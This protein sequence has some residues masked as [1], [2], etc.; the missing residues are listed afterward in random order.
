MNL[1]YFQPHLLAIVTFLIVTMAFFGPL[2]QGKHLKQ[3]DTMRWEGMAKEII[4]FRKSEGEEPLWTNS[5]FSGMPAFQISVLYPNNLISH[6]DQA[7]AK[8]FPGPSEIIFIA[9][10][11]FYFLLISFGLTPLA[12]VAGALAFAF[13]SYN[14]IIIEAGHNTKGFAIG[15]MAIVVI[16]VVMAFRGKYLL[17]SALAALGVAF[18]VNANHLQITY[19]T[20]VLLLVFGIVETVKNIKEKT[21][22]HYFKAVSFLF[23]AAVIGVL[24]NITSLLMT[25]EYGKETIRGKSELTLNADVKTSGLD[26]DYATQWSYGIGETM[27][28]MVPNFKGGGSG[29]IGNDKSVM[30]V[31]DPQMKQYVSGM[32]RYFGDQ[33]F[34]SGPVYFGAIVCFLFILGLFIVQGHLKW[35]LLI[36]TLL[37]VMLAWGKNFMPLTDFFLDFVPGYNKF[38]AVSMTLVIAQIAMPLLGFLAI[39]KIMEQPAI[40]KEK[41]KQFLVAF[42]LTGGL[43]FLMYFMPGM[44]NDFFKE[45][46]NANLMQ[47]L[48]SNKWPADQANLLLDNLESA[49]KSIFTSDAARSGIFISLSALLVWLFSRGQL[50]SLYMLSGLLALITIDQWTV[51]KRYMNEDNFTRKN[52]RAQTFEPSEADLQILQDPDPHYRVLNVTTSTFN[53]AATSYFH[54]SVGGYHGAKLKRYQEL[55]EYHL[56]QNN[57]DVINMLNT[58]YFIVPGQD[59]RPVAQKNPAPLG[60][61]WFVNEYEMVANADSEITAL[62]SFTPSEVAIVDQRFDAYLKGLQLKNKDEGSIKLTKY[63]PNY[64]SYESTT[65]AEQLAVFSEVYYDKGWNAYI[66]DKLVDHIRANYVLRAL[67]VPEGKHKIEFKFEPASYIVGERIALAGSIFAFLFIGFALYSEQKNGAKIKND[68]LRDNAEK[69]KQATAKIKV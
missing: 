3:E 39:K 51:A 28:L 50:K 55:I 31:V 47:Q 19:Y 24:P 23:I 6:I 27:T 18:Q 33:P 12:A 35:W 37:S 10:L 8:I 34:T 20:L 65:S 17:G 40:I 43:S 22:K 42:G 52:V 11:T 48:I 14:V 69:E 56:S 7:L 38:R 67:R 64:L 59:K 57:M 26:K 61:A 41:Q 60:N 36:A 44:F 5:M 32:D 1:K 4:D 15:Y 58:K 25:W 62:S 53:D 46:E 45:G 30:K 63:Q 54:K 29:Q 21:Y 13:S 16:G 9:L 68:H 49:R 2:L 66:D